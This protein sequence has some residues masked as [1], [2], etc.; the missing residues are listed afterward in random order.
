MRGGIQHV[1]T[2][3]YKITGPAN[4]AG[5]EIADH[6]EKDAEKE[7]SRVNDQYNVVTMSDE[8][9]EVYTAVP[10][11]NNRTTISDKK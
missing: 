5:N 2:I 1:K 4:K 11:G 3:L 9:S 7:A 8:R 10:L 6:L